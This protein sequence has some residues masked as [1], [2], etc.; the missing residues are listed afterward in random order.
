MNNTSTS[1]ENWSVYSIN[2]SIG[3]SPRLRKKH[4]LTQGTPKKQ[5]PNSIVELSTTQVSRELRGSK[6]QGV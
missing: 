2:T 5:F 3:S 1:F 6:T 4:L